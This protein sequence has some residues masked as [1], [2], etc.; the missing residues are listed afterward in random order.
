MTQDL[1][2][3]RQIVTY[4]QLEVSRMYCLSSGARENW[5]VISFR[6]GDVVR[7]LPVKDVLCLDS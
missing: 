2:R 6:M 1:Y 5:R 3:F 4:V 7:C